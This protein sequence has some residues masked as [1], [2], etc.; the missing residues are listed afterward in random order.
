MNN[1]GC[2]GVLILYN[3]K[4]II[5]FYNHSCFKAQ[6]GDFV[7]AFD[8]PSKESAYKT[9]RFQ[10]DIVLISHN[11]KNHNGKDV[12]SLK[13]ESEFFTLDT[14]GEYEIK[15]VMIRGVQSEINEKDEHGINTIFI[16]DMED[17][18]L[19]HMGDF[20]ENRISSEIKEA[21]G[22]VDILFF[23]VGAEFSDSKKGAEIINVIEPSIV[24]PMH[25]DAT[26]KN[27]KKLAEFLKEFS[28]DQIEKTDKLTIKKK[29]LSEENLKV[30][31]LESNL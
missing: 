13:E 1:K 17:I 31:V 30:V 3:K 19:C 5:S 29:D 4:M 20:N 21:L 26:E 9:P 7:V 24:I 23:P 14:P 25:Y 12:L 22:R 28:E 6:A 2:G 15:G 27:N 11:N 8:P 16:V 10:T 18:R